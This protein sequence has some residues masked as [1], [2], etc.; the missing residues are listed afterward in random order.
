MRRAVVTVVTVVT[1]AAAACGGEPFTMG[2]ALVGDA[3]PTPGGDVTG[4]DAAPDV[5]P[6][7]TVEGGQPTEAGADARVADAT[8]IPPADAP[9][10]ADAPKVDGGAADVDAGHVPGDVGPS[11]GGSIDA[12]ADVVA[13]PDVVTPPD[14]PPPACGPGTC[15]GCCMP[16]GECVTGATVEACGRGGRACNVCPWRCQ[17]G[18]P[19]AC[20]VD[21]GEM[22]AETFAPVCTSEGSCAT[23]PVAKCCGTS[24]DSCDPSRGCR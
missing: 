18:T 3:G 17:Y 23:E 15:S 13:P 14:A 22:T 24:P 21:A 5:G 19:W 10:G 8:P 11:E 7:A 1:L 4:Q 2:A 16:T 6:D 20:G 12:V 9:T